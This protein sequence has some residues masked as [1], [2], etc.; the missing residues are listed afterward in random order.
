MCVGEWGCGVCVVQQG[1]TLIGRVLVVVVMMMGVRMTATSEAAC[2]LVDT[3]KPTIKRRA[4]QAG[5]RGEGRL[6]NDLGKRQFPIW[7]GAREQRRPWGSRTKS[8]LLI[9]G[10]RRNHH[11]D[12]AGSILLPF[13]LFFFLS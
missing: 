4:S 3:M 10:D 12:V 9:L 1:G 11:H 5:Q 8:L 2:L 6:I 13:G 7:C